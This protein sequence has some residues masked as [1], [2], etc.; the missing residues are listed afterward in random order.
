[1]KLAYVAAIALVA[2]CLVAEDVHAEDKKDEKVAAPPSSRHARQGC[3]VAR[4]RL[5]SSKGAAPCRGVAQDP[6]WEAIVPPCRR[7]SS[8]LRRAGR[9][10]GAAQPRLRSGSLGRG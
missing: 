9:R 1:M 6:A 4:W 2:V 5:G 7:H 3:L 8:A 10:R